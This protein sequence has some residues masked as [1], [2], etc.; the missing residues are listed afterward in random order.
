M[1]AEM[2][3][4]ATSQ[5]ASGIAA[6]YAPIVESSPTSFEIDPPSAQE[7]WRRV[8]ETLPNYPW[9]VY[10]QQGRVAGYAYASRH[11]PRAA[12]AWSVDT[13]V[14]IHPDFHRRG[15]GRALYLALFE[16]LAAQGY[17]TAFAGVTLPNPAS[18]GLH[19]SLGFQPIGIYRNVG[20]K[21]GTWHDVAW[22]QRPL[23]PPSATPPPPL[24]LAAIQVDPRRPQ[25]L[26]A[27]LNSIKP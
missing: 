17:C 5:D 14:Y 18:V 26:T 12:Y 22:W 25:L 16:I 9:L 19:E 27:G 8:E 20:H 15:I 23:Q 24:S 21:H 7:M 6:I 2:I 13:S 1:V 10:E 3:R 11:K 4:L